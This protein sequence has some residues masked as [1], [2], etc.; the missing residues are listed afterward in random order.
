MTKVCKFRGA[1][2]KSLAG[3]AHMS[4]DCV[5]P[6]KSVGQDVTACLEGC[7]TSKHAVNERMLGGHSLQH[8]IVS[9]CMD[10]ACGAGQG[11][12]RIVL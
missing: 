2:S 5:T 8:A 4:S 3:E 1:K 9:S 7:S 12:H 10:S 6:S 11:N